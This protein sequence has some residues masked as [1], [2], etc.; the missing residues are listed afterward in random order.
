MTEQTITLK[1][2]RALHALVARGD[3]G[4]RTS[5]KTTNSTIV[6]ATAEALERAGYATITVDAGAYVVLATDAGR[7]YSSAMWDRGVR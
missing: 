3:K 7:S 2:L 1:Q 6:Y 4:M 5:G